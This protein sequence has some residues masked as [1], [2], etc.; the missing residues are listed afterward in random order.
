MNKQTRIIFEVMVENGF[1]YSF[2]S[3]KDLNKFLK[4]NSFDSTGKFIK[5]FGASIEGAWPN[6]KNL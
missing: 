4:N 3:I 5:N 1:R 6:E 2:D